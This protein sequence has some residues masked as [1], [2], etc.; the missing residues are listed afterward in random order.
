MS[1]PTKQEIIN[2]PIRKS[3]TASMK[4][5]KTEEILPIRRSSRA[6]TVK[7]NLCDSP[8]RSTRATKD[9]CD[10]PRRS[11]RRTETPTRVSR[12]AAQ[13]TDVLT[14]SK[15][16]ANMSEVEPEHLMCSPSKHLVVELA[17]L[18]ESISS[19]VKLPLKVCRQLLNED[20]KQ[21]NSENTH[22]VLPDKTIEDLPLS[23]VKFYPAANSPAK[24]Q[25][26]SNSPLKSSNIIN[27]ASPRKNISSLISSLQSPSKSPVK[28]IR[29]DSPVKSPLKR[30]VLER[31][32][33][34]PSKVMSSPAKSPLKRLVMD[35]PM[36]S[37]LKNLDFG[38]P[39]RSPRKLDQ[40]NAQSPRRTPRKLAM[41][42]LKFSSPSSMI[43]K[44][45]LAS[46]TNSRKNAAVGISK[47]NVTAYRAVRQSLN[48]GTPTT[49]VCREKQVSEMESF[50]KEHLLNVKP[51]SLYVSGAPGTGKTA[52]LNSI[53]D[54]M[55]LPSIKKVFL[56]C[57]TLRTAGA[58]YAKIVSELGLQQRGTERENI[59]AIEKTLTSGK[60]PVLIMLDE[61]DQLDSRNQE[62][63]Y[64]IFEWPAL[65]G[66]KLVLVGIANA[67][68]L[69]DRILPRLQARPTFKPKLLHFPPYSKAEIIKIINQRIQE[70]GLGDVQVIKPTAVMFL[71]GKVASVAG[72]V[73]KALDVCRRAVELCEIQ[74]RRQSVLKPTNGSPSKSP[75]K[76][77]SPPPMKM[78]EVPQ[79]LAI[80]NEVYGSRVI[81]AVTDAPDS[82]PLQQ[83]VLICSL[84][85]IMKHAK[86]KDLNLG[87]FHDVYTKICKKRNLP[88]IDQSEFL[89]LC[90]L[91]E[92]RG[93]LQIKKA[94]EIRSSKVI[95][96]LNVD[97][98][99]QT[100]GDRNLLVAILEDKE[101]LGKLC[102]Q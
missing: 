31:S 73:R 30:L 38:S 52:S 98:A 5:E 87:K 26:G 16:K 6:R 27:I 50:M 91:L 93:M 100:L 99:E 90:T 68:D 7:E 25:N 65:A 4:A 70:A 48:T 40:E 71:A 23:P 69:T 55:K 75:T 56:N 74:A 96:R 101:S 84:L 34:S 49:L 2:F 28:S 36:K 64:S 88:G 77:P 39:R 22:K 37:P 89:S 10:S 29:L 20:S 61:I 82:F 32:A 51:G 43:S 80:F 8:R 35:G 13:E 9:A 3:R 59:K 19:P 79:V 45:S 60:N 42:P 94:K 62:V 47:P 95:L 1:M 46:P 66:S 72:D 54:S 24:I 86:S 12:A 76:R 17:R 58:I 85:L 14:P 18:P 102:K 92:S 78:V 44:L 41:S 57:M 21:E 97:E 33:K 83:K 67:L 81:S 53:I 63:L 11:S 15:R